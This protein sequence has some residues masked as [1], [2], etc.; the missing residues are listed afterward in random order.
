MGDRHGSVCNRT[1]HSSH[2]SGTYGI[3]C[4]GTGDSFL[5][6]SWFAISPGLGYTFGVVRCVI[7]VEFCY[8]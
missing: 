2:V 4:D 8:D 3:N 5:F 7:I 6:V 1:P